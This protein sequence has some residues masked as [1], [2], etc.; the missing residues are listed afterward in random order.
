M[1]RESSNKR[2]TS[3]HGCCL[4]DNVISG[5]NGDCGNTKHVMNSKVLKSLDDTLDEAL[6]DRIME[7]LKLNISDV[8]F[9]EREMELWIKIYFHL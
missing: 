5:K 8:D 3:W 7:Q 1:R 9:E 2:F 4:L 6:R